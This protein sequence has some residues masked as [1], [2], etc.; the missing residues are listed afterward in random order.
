[1][2]QLETYNV[3]WESP[4]RHSGESM[5][6]GGHDIGLNAWVEHGDLLFY[7]DRSGSF[8]E[9][10]QMLKLGRVRLRL[11]PNPFVDGVF[12]QE[13][14]LR[15]G[16]LEVTGTL[17]DGL[18]A[19]V[20]LWVDVFRPVIHIEVNSNRPIRSAIRYESWRLT[21]R[22]V[23]LDRRMSSTSAVGYPGLVTTK[24]DQVDFSGD[25]IVF[26]HRNRSDELF[27]DKV[28]ALEGLA[29]YKD[30]LW[31]PQINNTFGG[32]MRGDGMQAVGTVTGTYIQTPYTAWTLASTQPTEQ[33]HAAIY[34][35]TAQAPTA[36]S[37]L[38]Q[39]HER[40]RDAEHDRAGTRAATQQWW[41]EFWQRSAISVDPD[42][43]LADSKPWQV[44]RNYTLFR[45][46]LGC[47]ATASTRPSSTAGSLPATRVM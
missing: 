20:R 34:L 44:G 10:N 26:Y 8:D 40:I 24:P 23:P 15:E 27:F 43:K 42:K 6:V 1:M 14:K 32:L 36:E 35:H 19:R 37:W 13:L 9:N 38:A 4:S 25:D 16:H 17:A 47:N 29:A 28:V 39:L 3:V 45:Y 12:R 30:Q 41:A 21:A 31:N 7:I 2:Q 5:P 22:E 33:Q 18:Q 11:D 46:M